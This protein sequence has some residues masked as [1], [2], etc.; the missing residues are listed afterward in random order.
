MDIDYLFRHGILFGDKDINATLDSI[1]Y[2]GEVT[3]E[4]Y[5][6][7]LVDIS[8]W[9][10][11]LHG[12]DNLGWSIFH[13]ALDPSKIGVVRK[14]GK[15]RAYIMNYKFAQGQGYIICMPHMICVMSPAT[16]SLS[17]LTEI[18]PKD[19][20]RSDDIMINQSD[21]IDYRYQS[22]EVVHQ[23]EPKNK[24][25]VLATDIYGFA[26]IAWRILTSIE[27]KARYFSVRNVTFDQISR[28]LDKETDR[29]SFSKQN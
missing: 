20:A 29:T 12:E 24:R 8:W 19:I 7:I 28:Y 16:K 27:S 25:F 26:C 4:N 2:A 13:G 5:F 1:I 22:W 9:L 21:E 17:S 10:M 23:K 6:Q 18:S 14:N 15:I 11:K 3:I